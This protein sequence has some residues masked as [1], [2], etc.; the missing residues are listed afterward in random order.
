MSRRNY[1]IYT[2]REG[3]RFKFGNR[4]TPE[5]LEEIKRTGQ[6]DVTPP[7]IDREHPGFEPEY[8]TPTYVALLTVVDEFDFHLGRP[9]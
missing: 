8:V 5:E 2:T 7:D 9:R 3:D 6:I 1:L 4:A